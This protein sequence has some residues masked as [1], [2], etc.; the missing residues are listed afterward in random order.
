MKAKGGGPRLFGFI[1]LWILMIESGSVFGSVVLGATSTF[2]WSTLRFDLDPGMSLIPVS[3]VSHA[4]SSTRRDSIGITDSDSQ[5]AAD[6]ATDL[7]SSSSFV[8]G[9]LDLSGSSQIV[10]DSMTGAASMTGTFSEGLRAQG[11]SQRDFTF[12]VSGSGSITISVDFTR[13]TAASNT[14]GDQGTAFASSVLTLNNLS[15]ANGI[16]LDPDLVDEAAAVSTLTSSA[17][18]PLGGSDSDSDSGTIS[19]SAV[20]SDGDLMLLIGQA[21]SDVFYTAAE[22]QRA[23]EPVTIGLIAIGLLALR[24]TRRHC[25]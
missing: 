12:Q 7:S 22:V 17:R 8:A 20:L 1:V 15:N 21:F 9:G 19:L 13:N 2:D 24:R 25:P 14:G 10:G 4:T 5:F 23:P 3:R 11:G 18:L 6:W 16:L